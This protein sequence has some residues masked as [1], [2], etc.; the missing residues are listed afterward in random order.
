MTHP[1]TLEDRVRCL[2]ARLDALDGGN[3]TVD[4]NYIRKLAR[5]RA[6]DGNALKVHN[7][8]RKV[9]S[10]REQSCKKVGT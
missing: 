2:E 1:I 10:H 6:V 8:L 5:A 3:G 7:A 4:L 9:N